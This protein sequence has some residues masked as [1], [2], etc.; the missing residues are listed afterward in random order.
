MVLEF[1]S[2]VILDKTKTNGIWDNKPHMFESYVILDKT[3][4]ITMAKG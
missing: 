3:K 2:Y 1:E 4:T